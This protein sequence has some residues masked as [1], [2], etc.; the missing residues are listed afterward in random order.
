MSR[1]SHTMDP[2][3]RRRRCPTCNALRHGDAF[4]HRC[5]SDLALLVKLEQQV[6]LL[7]RRAGQCYGRGWYRQAAALADQALALETRDDNHRML[8]CA[9]LLEGDFQAAL[10]IYVRLRRTSTQ[11]RYR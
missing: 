3:S 5:K 11:R 1:L 2:P 9:R 8:A 10:R 4:C 6:D 7:H